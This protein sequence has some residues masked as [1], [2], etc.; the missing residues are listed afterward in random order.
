MY[1]DVIEPIVFA[2]ENLKK[3]K[4]LMSTIHTLNT[5]LTQQE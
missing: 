3:M 4:S 1:I 5:K 2:K